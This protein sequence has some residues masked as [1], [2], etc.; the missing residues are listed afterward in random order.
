MLA[1]QS[2]ERI[3]AHYEHEYSFPDESIKLFVR[4]D[5]KTTDIDNAPTKNV[6][7]INLRPRVSPNLLQKP[8]ETAL[9]ML[10]VVTTAGF[11]VRRKTQYYSIPLT[12]LDLCSTGLYCRTITFKE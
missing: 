12:C 7:N 4:G 3:I 2:R 6:E 10:I 8:V 9:R 11:L 5:K 1:V